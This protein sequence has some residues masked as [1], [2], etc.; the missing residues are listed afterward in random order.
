MDG[1][2]GVYSPGMANGATEFQVISLSFS[3]TL[4]QEAVVSVRVV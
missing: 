3:E 1:E 4:G 2:N